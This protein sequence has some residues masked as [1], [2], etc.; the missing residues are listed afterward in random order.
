[1]RIGILA[2]VVSLLLGAQAL[3]APLGHGSRL[4]S[5]GSAR[6]QR[7]KPRTRQRKQRLRPRSS[8]I[9]IVGIT[10]GIASGKSTVSATLTKLGAKIVDADLLAREV[11]KPGK[12][13]Y[14]DIV[15]TFGKKVLQADKTIDRQR[16]GAIIFADVKQRAK[17]DKIV[18]PRITAAARNAIAKHDAAGEKVVFYDAALLVEKGLHRQVDQMVVVAV[19]KA[20]QRARLMG[21]DKLSKKAADQRIASQFPLAKKAALADLVIDNSG[22]RSQTKRQVQKLWRALEFADTNP[23]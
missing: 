7:Q 5:K 23:R 15:R 22:S 8:K 6:L 11:V 20:V 4:S 13:A 1:M 18:M 10:G 12:A 19:P 2:I 3:A 9:R 21:R 16:L 14:R 17:L